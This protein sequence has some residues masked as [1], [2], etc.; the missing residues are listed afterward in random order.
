MPIGGWDRLLPMGM[1]PSDVWDRLIPCPSMEGWE[2][3][4]PS[5]VSKCRSWFPRRM[6]SITLG[7]GR[8]AAPWPLLGGSPDAMLLSTLLALC[9]LWLPLIAPDDDVRSRLDLYAAGF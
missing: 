1:P 5:P 6:P 8:L 7:E 2:R 9:L 4:F 3:L